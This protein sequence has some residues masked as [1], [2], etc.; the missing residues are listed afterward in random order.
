M[1]LAWSRHQYA[2]VVWNQKVET[3][4]GCHRRAFEVFGGVPAK[5]DDHP[6]CAITK[7]CYYDPEVKQS[8]GPIP[9]SP[10]DMASSSPPARQGYS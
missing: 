10:R 1:T 4:L 5:V 2:E 6:K 7:A 9:K 3:W 8:N